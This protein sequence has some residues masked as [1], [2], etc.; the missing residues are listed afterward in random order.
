MAK[1]LVTVT[2]TGV[3]HCPIATFYNSFDAIGAIAEKMTVAE[4]EDVI[5]HLE[6]K[7]SVD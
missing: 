6:D 4:L 5:R 1:I 3:D 7:Y 2:E